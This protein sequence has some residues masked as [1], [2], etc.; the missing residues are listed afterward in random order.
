MPG[1]SL[2]S[3]IDFKRKQLRNE[4]LKK[5]TFPQLVTEHPVTFNKTSC[6]ILM[7]F[8]EFYENIHLIANFMLSPYK[9]IILKFCI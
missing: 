9:K 8:H 4:R 7:L 1:A 5:S 2:L 6:Q 3:I